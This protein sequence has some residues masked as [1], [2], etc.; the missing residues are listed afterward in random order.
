ML[1][2]LAVIILVGGVVPPVNSDVGCSNPGDNLHYDGSGL[3]CGVPMRPTKTVSTLPACN[4]AARGQMALV[5][6]ALLPASLASVS[7][8]GAVVVGV[9]CNGTTWIVQ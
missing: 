7:G 4:T 5:T 2:E 3:T 9:V 8:G 6:D 1:K